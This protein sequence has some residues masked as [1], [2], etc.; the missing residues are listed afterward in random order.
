MNKIITAL[1]FVMSITANLSAQ[2]GIGTSSPDASAAL[3]ITASDKGLLI[4][5]MTTAQRMAITAPANSLM[6]FDTDTNSQ[7]LYVDS[8][9]VE[10]KAGVGKF[11]DGAAADIAYYPDRVWI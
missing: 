11:V 7:W 6:V 9:W 3:D 1:V 4:P 10:S 5:R 8:A 2:V